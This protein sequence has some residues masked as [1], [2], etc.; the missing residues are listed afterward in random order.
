MTNAVLAA[1][2]I[3]TRSACAPLRARYPAPHEHRFS[4]RAAYPPREACAMLAAQGVARIVLSQPLDLG[5]PQALDAIRLIRDC[6][7]VG[8]GVDWS[9]SSTGA[10]DPVELMHLCPPASFPGFE[11]LL[12]SWRDFSFGVLYWRR[13]PDFA[14]VRDIRPAF[15]PAWYE[16]ED[17]ASMEL[18]GRLC[19][20]QPVAECARFGTAFDE[21]RAARLVLTIG[22]VCLAL[23]YRIH[24]WPVPFL[25]V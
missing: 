1:P 25:S 6:V 8:V 4:A 5:D 7:A 9:V 24:K 10:V 15:E 3:P 12:D 19:E 21:L 11:P 23:P 14:V 2:A 18:F 17:P 13:G 16:L 20:P 22:D